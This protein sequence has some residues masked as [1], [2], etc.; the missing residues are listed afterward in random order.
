MR[1]NNPDSYNAFDG[2]PI[3]IKEKG[4]MTVASRHVTIDGTSR[5]VAFYVITLNGWKIP[6]YSSFG[7]DVTVQTPVFA[8]NDSPEVTYH[9][10]RDEDS[11]AISLLLYVNIIILGV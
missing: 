8:I 6:Y 4:L 1:G 3:L 10:D 11:Y 5:S 9:V 2:W 7:P